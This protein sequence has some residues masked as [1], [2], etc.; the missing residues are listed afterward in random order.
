LSQFL[1]NRFEIGDRR[2]EGWE[3]Q[4]AALEFAGDIQPELA[5]GIR[6]VFPIFSGVRSIPFQ[7]K[8]QRPKSCTVG[9]GPIATG[10][11]GLQLFQEAPFSLFQAG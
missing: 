11:D 2:H 5:Q 10:I 6:L 3:R 8:T 9:I 7:H 4:A 1:A